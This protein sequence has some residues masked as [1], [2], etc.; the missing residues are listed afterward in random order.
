MID[1]DDTRRHNMAHLYGIPP[2]DEI[3]TDDL[4]H[5][6][7]TTYTVEAYMAEQERCQEVIDL[8]VMAGGIDLDTWYDRV[9]HI[10][11]MRRIAADAE[12]A[13]RAQGDA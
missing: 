3:D 1:N 11:G 10:E 5:V 6:D 9:G 7:A 2:L 13:Y 4:I 8:H 12:R